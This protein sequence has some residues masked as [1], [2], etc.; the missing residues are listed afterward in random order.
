MMMPCGVLVCCLNTK[1]NHRGS[2]ISKIVASVPPRGQGRM[3]LKSLSSKN[4]KYRDGE[5]R[6]HCASGERLD[7]T[8]ATVDLTNEQ[9]LKMLVKR[10]NE[11]QVEAK[12]IYIYKSVLFTQADFS[13]MLDKESSC[14]FLIELN[15]P[16][17]AASQGYSFIISF[18]KSLALRERILPFC[19]GEVWVTTACLALIEATTFDYN[20]SGAWHRKGVLSS[21]GTSLARVKLLYQITDSLIWLGIPVTYLSDSRGYEIDV[22]HAYIWSLHLIP[23]SKVAALDSI[24]HILFS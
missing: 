23:K 6:R 2:V 3:E 10:C 16:I 13:Q 7:K 11:K 14:Q 12:T 1:S 20:S 21:S 22:P 17:E 8:L 4:D 19:M 9:L 5:K 18:S 24:L 15:H